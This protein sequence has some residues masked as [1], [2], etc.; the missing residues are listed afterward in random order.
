[1]PR[2]GEIWWVRLDPKLGSKIAKTRPCLI[3][4]S[5]GL[6][7][8]RRTVVIVPLSSSPQSSPLVPV[9]CGGRDV[10]GVTDQ[11]RAVSKERLD[12]CIETLSIEGL[13]AVERG[14]REILELG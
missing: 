9:R 13:E 2:R 12:R 6:N 5:D 3:L 10:V 7:Q 1:L 4:S 8:R 11:I 14:V